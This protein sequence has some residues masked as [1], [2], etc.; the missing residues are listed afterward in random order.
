MSCQ[1]SP[2]SGCNRS[3]CFGARLR[4]AVLQ[5]GDKDRLRFLPQQLHEQAVVGLSKL[6][7]VVVPKHAALHSHFF[8][9][10]GFLFQ[11][12]IQG[13]VHEHPV[14]HAVLERRVA[15]LTPRRDLLIEC[16]AHRRLNALQKGCLGVHT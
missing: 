7:Q 12:T 3:R 4:V 13:L 16:P 14:G 5:P 15:A 9:A 10:A 6:Y 11:K 8:Q 1:P 2:I